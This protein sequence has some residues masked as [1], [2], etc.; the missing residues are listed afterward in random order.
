M[1]WLVFA[2]LTVVSWGLYGVLLHTGQIAM[3]DPV[4]GRYKAFLFV[5]VAYLL[6]AV[7][8]SLIVLAYNGASWLY[9]TKGVFWVHRRWHR[10]GHRRIG[11]PPR[12]RRKGDAGRGHVHRL[13]R[14]SHRQRGCRR[15]RA[16]AR[17]AAGAAVRWPFVLGIVLAATGGCLVTF[18]RPGN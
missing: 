4:N 12:V 17:L 1:T 11:R 3:S 16:S 9:P 10:R 13:C 14:C 7:F 8:G 6:T 18:F 5:G 15:A 2:L